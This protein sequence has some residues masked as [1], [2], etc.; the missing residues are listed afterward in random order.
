[1][2]VALLYLGD[3][4]VD[5]Q[6]ND[7]VLIPVE[8]TFLNRFSANFFSLLFGGLW[9]YNTSPSN[10]WINGT[11]CWLS[12]ALLPGALDWAH[13]H[14][15]FRA[16]PDARNCMVCAMP[17]PLPGLHNSLPVME[18]WADLPV[19]MVLANGVSMGNSPTML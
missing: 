11:R 9:V 16:S 14:S 17:S 18:L 19:N 5:R 8:E 15:Y 12:N 10:G 1:M 13:P 4:L 7:M 6:L 3:W 2:Y